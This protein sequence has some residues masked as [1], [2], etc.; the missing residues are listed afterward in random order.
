M[1]RC[2]ICNAVLAPRNAATS[3]AS[4]RAYTCSDCGSLLDRIAD[5][6]AGD[7]TRGKWLDKL[8]PEGQ[9]ERVE[10]YTEMVANGHRLF[11]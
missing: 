3:D 4:L 8:P 1:R 9:V 10:K 6:H 11:E 2:L 5:A 7:G